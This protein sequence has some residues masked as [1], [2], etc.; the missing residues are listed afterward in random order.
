MAELKPYDPSKPW[1]SINLPTKEE[2]IAA[3]LGLIPGYRALKNMYDN[4]EGRLC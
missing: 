1:I 4:P 3:T 2:L